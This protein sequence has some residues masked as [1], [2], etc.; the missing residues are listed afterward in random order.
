MPWPK[1]PFHEYMD[2]PRHDPEPEPIVEWEAVQQHGRWVV[3]KIVETVEATFATYDEAT[4][5][6]ARQSAPKASG[7]DEHERTAE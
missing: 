2:R 5:F 1:M 3:V 7:S 6:I 4:H